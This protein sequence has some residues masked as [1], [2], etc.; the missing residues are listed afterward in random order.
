MRNLKLILVIGERGAQGVPIVKGQSLF[1]KV[2]T[3]T[4][5]TISSF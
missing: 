1:T 5:A 4:N 2:N 3:C